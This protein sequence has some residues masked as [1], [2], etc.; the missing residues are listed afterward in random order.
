MVALNRGFV[1][2]TGRLEV[3]GDVPDDLRGT[4]LLLASNHISNLDPMTLVAASRRIDLA[5]RFVLAG[6]LLGVPVVGW[7][8]RRS[9][10]LGVDRESGNA[11]AA[12]ADIVAA[13]RAGVPIVIYPEGKISLDPGLW[14]ERGKTGLARIA[15]GSGARVVPVSQW[16]AHEACYWG[17]L[18]VSGWQD[19]LPY[20]TS[21]L[22]SVRRRPALR[23]HFGA[24]VDLSDLSEGRPG[25]ARR[26]HER[27]MRAIADGLAPLRA[28]EP[29]LPAFHDPT[30]PTTG[31]SP[32]RPTA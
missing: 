15:L 9:G 17:N 23:V 16:G 20:L 2:L 8:L 32:W 24:P 3:T 30:R 29:D 4:P 5:P 28:D 19:L 11:A 21:W 18:K 6:G 12:M 25:D 1:A 14:P 27:I 13:L 31:S 26:A 22:R 10:H 7:V